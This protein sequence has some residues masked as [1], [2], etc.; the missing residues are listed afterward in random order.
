M[1]NQS[2]SGRAPFGTVL[3]YGP[4]DVPVYSSDYDTADP[5]DLPNRQAY[6][7]HVDGVFTG[8]KWQCVE[9]ARRWM[10]LTHGYIFDDIAMAYDIFRLRSVRVVDGESNLPLHSFRNGSKRHPEPGALLIWNEGG[11]FD[12]TGHVAIVT[13]VFPDSVRI[14]EQNVEDSVW[15]EERP[16]SRELHAAVAPDGG[17]WIECSYADASILGWVIQTDD[18]VHAEKIE[19][20]DRLLFDIRCLEAKAGPHEQETWLNIANP[21]EAA[22]V[23]AMGGCKL[24][25]TNETRLRYFQISETAFRE[26]KRATNEL[27]RMFMHATNYVLENDELLR[28]FNI[29]P[30]LYPRIHQ[31]WD[32]RRNEMITGRFD[33]SLSSRGLRVYEYNCDS[34]SCH[35]ECGKIQDKWAAH[36][37]VDDWRSSGQDVFGDLVDA[38][39]ESGVGGILHILQDDDPEETYHALYMKEAAE[40]AGLECKLIVGLDSL[41]WGS[42]GRVTDAEGN[43]ID[44][45]WKTWA[46]ETALDEIRG[47]IEDDEENLRRHRTMDRRT[48]KPRLVDV[49]LH[50]DVMVFEPLWTLIPSNKAI[51]PVL[52]MMFPTYPYLLDTRNELTEE[53]RKNGYV[54]KPIVGRWGSNIQIHDAAAGLVAET[55]GKFEAR[56]TIYQELFPLPVLDGLHV[57]IGTVTVA[58]AYSGAAVRADPT[59]IIGVDSD[60]HALRIVPDR[61]ILPQS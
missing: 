5:A 18:A 57:Q 46:W 6:L 31:S 10:Y 36:F 35:I 27:H 23:A 17:Y 29:P 56:D 37:G 39:K 15:P 24:A 25:E 7:N 8:Y 3:G 9:L 32:N 22:Y 42:D 14:I 2:P 4:G 40:R 1:T 30:A 21:D 60:I 33:F 49:L 16:W 54:A 43:G 53:L 34:A 58:G 12:V 55:S 50:P 45:V 13:E 11:E 28:T 48:T 47:Q 51:L 61:E 19:E 26:I 52:K 38:W 20:V 59:P 44:W 41:K